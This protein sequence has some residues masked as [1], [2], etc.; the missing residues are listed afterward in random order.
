MTE[1]KL[2]LDSNP[3]RCP[4]LISCFEWISLGFSFEP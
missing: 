3:T 2:P 1:I 4:P